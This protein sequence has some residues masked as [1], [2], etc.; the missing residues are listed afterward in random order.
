MQDQFLNYK[1]CKSMQ[2]YSGVDLQGVWPPRMQDGKGYG[3]QGG[4]VGR[5][6]GWDLGT[7]LTGAYSGKFG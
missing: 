3:R 1:L 6:M 7:H 4:N 5:G 2:E